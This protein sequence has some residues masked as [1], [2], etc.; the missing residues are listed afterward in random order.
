[1]TANTNRILRLPATEQKVG[2]KRDAICRGAR[3]GWFPKPVQISA[4]ATGWPEH[5]LDAFIASRPRTVGHGCAKRNPH[6]APPL[7]D[8][9]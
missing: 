4:R 1:M 3:E 9:Q 5:E 2:L 6:K 7:P 8:T